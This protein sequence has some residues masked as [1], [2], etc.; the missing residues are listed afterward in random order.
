MV[1]YTGRIEVCKISRKLILK[2]NDHTGRAAVANGIAIDSW[3][4]TV[5]THIPAAYDMLDYSRVR[6]AGTN[7]PSR[8]ERK[9]M[10]LT[11]MPRFRS[12]LHPIPT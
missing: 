4:N 8:F 10:L 5:P 1:L 12:E 3:R 7:F 2:L 11:L 9:K 6:D